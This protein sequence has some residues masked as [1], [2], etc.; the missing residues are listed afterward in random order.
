MIRSIVFA[1]GNKAPLGGENGMYYLYMEFCEQHGFRSVSKN[2]FAVILDFMLHIGC[3]P[4]G[5]EWKDRPKTVR[6]P[7]TGIIM[8]AN[9]NLV[10]HRGILACDKGKNMYDFVH[11]ALRYSLS[12][13]CVNRVQ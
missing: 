8:Y 11:S 7:S 9:I 10:S 4:S 2:M 5:L 1:T 13:S 3:L 6:A 12:V